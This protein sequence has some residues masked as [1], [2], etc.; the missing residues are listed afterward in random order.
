VAVA[1]GAMLAAMGA[2]HACVSERATGTPETAG[3]CDIPLPAEAFG[4]TIVV[5]RGFAFTPAQVR[6][7]PGAK[8]TWVNCE[9]A[10]S[11]AHTS[12]SDAGAWSSPLL[13]PK[14]TFTRVF[15]V[16]GAFPYHC[17]PHPGM[18]ATVTVE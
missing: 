7:R 5:I 11:D 6:V 2:L 13:A 12:T 15:A 16:V 14:S 10:A 18:R 17:A 3:G 4:S 9:A 8:V 1:A